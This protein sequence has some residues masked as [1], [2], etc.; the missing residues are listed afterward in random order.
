MSRF[1]SVRS[2][3]LAGALGMALATGSA[4]AAPVAQRATPP[5]SDPALALEPAQGGMLDWRHREIVSRPPA[6]PSDPRD[7]LRGARLDGVADPGW[8]RVVAH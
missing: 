5:A 4:A 8:R 6:A 2:L 3:L 1:E 7:P